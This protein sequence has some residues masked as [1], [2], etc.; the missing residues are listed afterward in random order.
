MTPEPD[1]YSPHTSFRISADLWRRFGVLVGAKNRAGLLR[2]F[3]RWYMREPKA[4]LP[5]R[6]PRR[7]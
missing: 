7:D 5:E 3:I 4:K 6:P 2:D 1:S